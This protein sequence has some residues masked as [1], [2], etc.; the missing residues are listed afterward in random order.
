MVEIGLIGREG[1]SGLP[2]VMGSETSPYAAFVQVSG[3]GYRIASAAIREIADDSRDLREACLRYGHVFLT[4]VASS[5]AANSQGKLDERLARWL[6]MTHDRLQDDDLPLTHEFLSMMLGVH[7][8]G[9]TI[10]LSLLNKRGMVSIG[11]G[12]ITITDRSSLQ[13]FAAGYYGEAEN[14]ERKLMSAHSPR[15][16]TES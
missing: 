9:V 16:R 1:F 3:S 11:R 15:Q 14:E 6:L 12:A 13:K 4:Q 7:R 8:P 5:A 2:L 10:A